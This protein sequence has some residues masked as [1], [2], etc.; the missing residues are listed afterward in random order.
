MRQEGHEFKDSLS[1]I[2]RPCLKEK[3][4]KE[5]KKEYF[6]QLAYWGTNETIKNSPIG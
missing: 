5:R 4:K 3:K 2:A 1:Y 6:L